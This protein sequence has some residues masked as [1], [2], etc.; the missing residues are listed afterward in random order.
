M[1]LVCVLCRQFPESSSPLRNRLS[2][3]ARALI[4]PAYRFCSIL[5]K[6]TKNAKA[7]KELGFSMTPAARLWNVRRA[8]MS[9]RLNES[10]KTIE[11]LLAVFTLGIS[12]TS[13]STSGKEE[14][15]SQQPLAGFQVPRSGPVLAG[16][17]QQNAQGFALLST[18]KQAIASTWR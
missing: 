15:I 7:F 13:T 17:R 12:S 3:R 6:E 16:R 2:F 10:Q 1:Q 14:F 5:P 18:A 8:W 4:H 9:P 11:S